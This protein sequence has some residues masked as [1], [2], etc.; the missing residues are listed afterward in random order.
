MDG[1]MFR[2]WQE[3]EIGGVL[4]KEMSG[5]E[6][7]FL[8]DQIGRL[9]DYGPLCSPRFTKLSDYK[10][11]KPLFY[12]GKKDDDDKKIYDGDILNVDHRIEKSNGHCVVEWS[13]S[14]FCWRLRNIKNGLPFMLHGCIGTRI[15]GNKFQNLEL[16]KNE[17]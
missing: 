4:H 7:W 3:F 15:V 1:F 13:E 11:I 6:S 2:V 17:K 12:I 16:I 10:V 14:G 8:I 5:P 9:W